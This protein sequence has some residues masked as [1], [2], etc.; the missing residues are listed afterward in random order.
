MPSSSTTRNSPGTAVPDDY[1]AARNRLAHRARAG[2]VVVEGP[3]RADF[4]QGQLTQDVRGLAPGQSRLAAGLTAK[5]KLLYFGR[6]V[7]EADRFLLLLPAQAAPGVAG[8]L[9][10]YAAFQKASARDATAEFVRV[11]LYG[12]EAAGLQNGAAPADTIRLPPEWDHAGEL[13]APEGA[14]D[15]ILEGLSRAGSVPVSE[16]TSEILRVE[17]G[18]PRWGQDATEASLAG[19]VGL[20][21]AI[22]ATKGCYVGQEIVARMRTYGKMNRRLAGLRFPGGPVAPGT[23]FPDPEKPQ[24]ELARVTSAVVSPRFG[25]IGLGFVFRDVA[26]GAELGSAGPAAVVSALPFS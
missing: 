5:G 25:A 16:N 12:P 6:L 20:E 15:A 26:E 22:S 19:E 1:A 13:L 21:A 17:A 23:S 2:V 7:A 8:H 10:R 18:R 14:R 4:L 11:A 9:A 3:D 24:R